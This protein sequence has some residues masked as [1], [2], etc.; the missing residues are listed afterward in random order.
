MISIIGG[1]AVGNYLA[2]LLAKNGKKV[3]VYEEHNKIG[4]PVQCA[5]LV[6]SRIKELVP[7]RKQ[8]LVNKVWKIRLYSPNGDSF[9]LNLKRPNYI[10]NRMKFDRYLFEKAK[11]AGA[12][13]F[14]GYKFIGFENGKLKFNKGLKEKGIL[15]GADGP[16]SVVAKS[17]GLGK[18]RSYVVCLQARVKRYFEAEVICGYFNK[19]YWASVIP[20]NDNI[21]R[22]SLIAKKNMNYY[23]KNF[24]KKFRGKVIEYNSGVIPVY[25]PNLKT[26]KNNVY[27]VGD[28][29]GQ[30]KAS[31]FGGLVSGMIAAR[32]L[33]RAIIEGKN[34]EKLWRKKIGRELKKHLYVRRIF[35]KFSNR[36]YNYFLSLIKQDKVKKLLERYD[37]DNL[38]KYAWKLILIEPR[39]LK[40]LFN[41]IS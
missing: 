15:I 29:A 9:D 3:S 23:F 35:N 36:D 12:N 11:E 25:D 33:A 10:L 32:E 17:V 1:G 6:T 37:R 38:K 28:A 39:F 7:I 8:F 18:K 14:L 19:N 22:I 31:T 5:G 26:Q 40:F 27:L 34:Y 30:V 13:Y 41:L 21:A 2:Y 24:L 16:N 20:E 4:L